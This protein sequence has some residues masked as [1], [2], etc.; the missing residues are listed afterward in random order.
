MGKFSN[1]LAVAGAAGMVFLS[2]PAFARHTVSYE[3]YVT[4]A[5][6][7]TVIYVTDDK[8]DNQAVKGK[9]KYEARSSAPMHSKN[10]SSGCRTTTSM[11][12]DAMIHGIQACV[13]QDWQ[14]DDCSTWIYWE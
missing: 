1:V 12:T 8:C 9:W 6:S 5:A 10:N 7:G 4:V 14:P 3:S 13:V 11:T 2:D